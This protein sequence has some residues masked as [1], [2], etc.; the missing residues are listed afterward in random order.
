[1][2]HILLVEQVDVYLRGLTAI[3]EGHDLGRLD[4]ILGML[5]METFD[6]AVVSTSKPTRTYWEYLAPHL[7]IPVVLI[8]DENE[9][10]TM[11][12]VIQNANVQALV[13]R[14]AQ[15]SA[16]R[17]AVDAV[18]AGETY[19]DSAMSSVVGVA[20]A[21]KLDEI[22]ATGRELEVLEGVV[23]GQT[24]A[25]IAR[26]LGCTER[27]VKFHVSNLLRKAGATS[28]GDLAAELYAFEE[29]FDFG[30]GNGCDGGA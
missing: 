4:G 12:E 6:V 27:T 28:R 11:A 26:S 29:R 2:A 13:H 15:A 30:S 5:G 24:N 8:T 20:R 7:D 3:L 19:Y 18:L 16:V 25:A 14:H 22:G 17:A 10:R 9:W 21:A 23:K 1:M